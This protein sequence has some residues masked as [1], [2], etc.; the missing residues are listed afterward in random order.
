MLT[1]L[2]ETTFTLN[3][4]STA[5]FTSVFEI[6]KNSVSQE[7]LGNGECQIIHIN[8]GLSSY[9]WRIHFDNGVIMG[10][11]DVREYQLRNG[12]LPS[13]N[14]TIIYGENQ[15]EFTNI[16]KITIYR[17]VRYFTYG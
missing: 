11:N 9:G 5:F 8:I 3:N 12:S 17:S 7:I 4:C 1:V 6:D 14:G 2:T 10:I 16:N 13:S 15:I